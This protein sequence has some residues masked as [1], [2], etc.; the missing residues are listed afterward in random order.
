MA[1]VTFTRWHIV[2]SENLSR[3]NKSYYTALICLHVVDRINENVNF[4]KPIHANGNFTRIILF[5][6]IIFIR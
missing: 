3:Q 5:K 1:Y 4:W 2:S 6:S